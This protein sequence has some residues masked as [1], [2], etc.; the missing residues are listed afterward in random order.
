[1]NYNRAK[2][3]SKSP[4]MA[5]VTYNGS[6]VYIEQVNETKMAASIHLLND[7]SRSMEV[8]VDSLIEH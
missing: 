1:M 4:I 3:I 5:D 7:P 2:E 6:N 8:P